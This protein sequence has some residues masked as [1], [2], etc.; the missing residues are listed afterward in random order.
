MN[1]D[2]QAIG[3]VSFQHS[4]P[5]VVHPSTPVPPTP[6]SN[7][8][9]ICRLW[10]SKQEFEL[11]PSIKSPHRHQRFCKKCDELYNITEMLKTMSRSVV[12]DKARQ[13]YNR[14]ND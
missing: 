11:K 8:C 6:S 7:K 2:I 14:K 10:L 5:L 12:Y 4:L 1:K 3:S 9:K 13:Q